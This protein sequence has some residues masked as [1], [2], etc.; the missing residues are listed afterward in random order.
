MEQVSKL[1]LVEQVS[2]TGGTGV[3]AMLRVAQFNI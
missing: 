2:G 1:C 3:K